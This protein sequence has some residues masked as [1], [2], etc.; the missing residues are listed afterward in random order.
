QQWEKITHGDEAPPPLVQELFKRQPLR[1]FLMR[2]KYC[3]SEKRCQAHVINAEYLSCCA[4]AIGALGALE[5][6]AALK[7]DDLYRDYPETI[8]QCEE[9]FHHGFNEV[10]SRLETLE[11]DYPDLFRSISAATLQEMVYANELAAIDELL[12]RA[13][14]SD[15][16]YAELSSFFHQ[17]IRENSTIVYRKLLE[18]AES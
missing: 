17:R 4:I 1:D 3:E 18:T 5:R 10:Q 11:K 8:R 14:I 15:R 9:F 16:I 6:L 12:A 7:K 13:E 2:L